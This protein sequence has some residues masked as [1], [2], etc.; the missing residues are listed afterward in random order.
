M[1]A[2]PRAIKPVSW[3]VDCRASEAGAGTVTSPFRSLA[4][5]TSRS[6]PAG[7]SVA[8]ARGCAWDGPV[9]LR[10]DGT[11]AQPITLTAY[12]VGAAPVLRGG[13]SAAARGTVNLLGAYQVL[14]HVHVVGAA[15]A[16]VDVRA[17][18]ATVRDTEIENAGTG[19]TFNAPD[20]VAYRVRVHDLH[21][22]VDTPGGD[23]DY[24]AVGFNVQADRA[25]IADSS[26][27]NCRA[28][29]HD[30]GYDGGF[31]EV[32]NHG[33]DLFMH[34][35]IGRNTD[36]ILE[37]G[38]NLDTAS[39]RRIEVRDNHF[40][41]AH[42]GFVVHGS[43]KFAIAVPSATISDNTITVTSDRDGPVLS[44]SIRE[45]RFDRNAVTTRGMV[46]A[47]GAPASHRC[48][49][50]TVAGPERIGYT[51]GSTEV[52]GDQPRPTACGGTGSA[53]PSAAPSRRAP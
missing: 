29:S 28:P 47:S 30:Y 2:E 23:D 52:L 33:D 40:T 11:A 26:C 48:N 46:S 45:F 36:G 51:R 25:E 9:D 22:I 14:R 1:A 53:P 6:L 42:G 3:Y 4:D 44:G 37:I 49:V 13:P 31:A 16:G 34:D 10:G 7:S 50:Y 17:P 39:A 41:D 18:H 20:T 21:M 38:G 43:G 32:W 15:G 5:A 19:V 24:G 12:G 35:N 8:L 27:V